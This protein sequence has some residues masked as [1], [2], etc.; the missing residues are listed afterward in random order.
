KRVSEICSYYRIN[1]EALILILNL[2]L[3]PDYTPR[4]TL[5][6]EEFEQ[7]KQYFDATDMF[8]RSIQIPNIESHLKAFI[9]QSDDVSTLKMIEVLFAKFK[10]EFMSGPGYFHD[11]LGDIKNIMIKHL[12]GRFNTN[13]YY[14]VIFSL[15]SLEADLTQHERLRTLLLETLVKEI[16]NRKGLSEIKKKRNPGELTTRENDVLKLVVK[17][18]LNKEIASELSISFNTV[19]THRKNMISKLGIKSVPGLTLFAYISGLVSSQ[20]IQH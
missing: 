11:I 6:E 4:I 17:G 18:R 3:N 14:A 12:T 7:I 15:H 19:L 1:E 9:A 13:L 2:Y 16:P 5:D 20:E 8:Y 10:S